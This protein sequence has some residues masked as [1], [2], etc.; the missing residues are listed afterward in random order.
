MKGFPIPSS[1]AKAGQRNVQIIQLLIQSFSARGSKKEFLD[2]V[3]SLIRQESGCNFV[4]IRVL[5]ENG[6]IPYHAYV[7]FSQEFWEAE[8]QIQILKE[9]CSCTRI[10]SGNLLPFDKPVINSTGSLCCNDILLF[11]ETLSEDE[12][13]KY[14]GACIQAGYRSLAI[15]PIYH[16]EEMLG[17]IHLADFKADQL[18]AAVIELV[19]SIAPLVGEV[20]QRDK[21]EQSLKVLQDNAAILERIVGGISSLAYVV[22]LDTYELLHISPALR[23]LGGARVGC[24]CYENFGMSSPCC[25]CFYLK[26]Y[27]D[28][29]EKLSWERYVPIYDRYYLA[30]QKIIQWP[31]ERSMHVAFITDITQQRKAEK[32]LLASNADLEKMV[33]SLQQLS[34]TLEEE[35]MERQAT[36]EEVSQKAEEIRRMAYY[37]VLTRLPNRTY[38]MERLEAEMVKARHGK[39]SG[40]VIF[41]DL[42]D[43]RIINDTFGHTYGDALIVMAG[44]RIVQEA[45]QDAI[46]GRIGGDEFMII[47]PGL[48]ERESIAHIASKII[49]VF[50][51]DIQMLGMGFHMS[52]SAGIARYPDDGDRAEEVFKNA[53]NAMYAAKKNGKNCWRFY[54]AS[55]QAEAYNRILLINNLRYSIER[56]EFTLHYQPLVSVAEGATIGFE[57]LLRWNSPTYGPISP[58]I[59][60]P[61]AEQSGLIQRI[62]QWVL[63][64]ACCFIRQL[65]ERGWGHI[66][67]AVNISPHQLCADNFI[68]NVRGLLDYAG[69]EPSQ[70]ELEITETALIESLDDSIDKLDELR[71]MGIWL[72][73]DDFGTG[74][75]SL[76][77][78]QRL[79]VNTLKIDKAFIDRI[80]IGGGQK[81]IIGTI[82]EMAHVMG[83]NVVAEGVETL[84]QLEYLK[85]CYCDLIQG[86]LISRPIPAHEAFSFVANRL[87]SSKT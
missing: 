49:G 86:Y 67:V 78:L 83:M 23:E 58:A 66:R 45:G 35:I 80:F 74:Y 77:Y 14:R 30:E 36:Q 37:D 62:G 87:L 3:V 39:A 34:A 6:Y 81:A 82:V 60:I 59:F 57:A 43:I 84:E 1:Q 26:S 44:N 12:Q 7:G 28:S 19:E 53:D 25:D 11:A 54:E 29:E 51:H 32:E 55:M 21:I 24:K 5:D 79:P 61:I 15:I 22:D 85:Q 65:T 50:Y 40:A 63:R 20:L 18:N 47:L 71:S 16:Q 10:V 27:Q 70:L 2:Q 9:D 64:E 69:V 56:D 17:I 75:S 52:A 31:D 38:L 8:N 48:N 76:T 13:K 68:Q 33:V 46:V 41:I 73:L 4:G 72:S 42:D